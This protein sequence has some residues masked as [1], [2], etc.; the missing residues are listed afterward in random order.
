M[1]VSSKA[2]VRTLKSNTAGPKMAKSSDSNLHKWLIDSKD[3]NEAALKAV[4]N[5]HSWLRLKLS[6]FNLSSVKNFLRPSPPT[7]QAGVKRLVRGSNADAIRDFLKS[8]C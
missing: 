3:L 2:R 7:C 1:W 8:Q 4:T 5:L 6:P